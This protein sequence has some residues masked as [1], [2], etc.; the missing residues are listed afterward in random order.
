MATERWVRDK[1]HKVIGHHTR[2]N[3]MVSIVH[4]DGA[5]FGPIAHRKDEHGQDIHDRQRIRRARSAA[6]V[7]IVA[8]GVKYHQ[9]KQRLREIGHH[10]L[11]MI[12]TAIIDKTEKERKR[13][14][15]D[16]PMK[17]RATPTCIGGRMVGRVL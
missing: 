11:L 1:E 9:E 3:T 4:G 10:R 7:I 5:E 15:I 17:G 16:F 6:L 14:E 2:A 8:R 12:G 13:D